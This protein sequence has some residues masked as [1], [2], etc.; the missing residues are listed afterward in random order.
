[1]HTLAILFAAATVGFF[2]LLVRPQL[3]LRTGNSVPSRRKL[4]IPFFACW[5]LAA[6]MSHA[7]RKSNDSNDFQS[8]NGGENSSVIRASYA[9]PERK[10]LAAIFAGIKKLADLSDNGELQEQQRPGCNASVVQLV[11]ATVPL[12]DNIHAHL[13]ALR[14]SKT[15]DAEND[16]SMSPV[17]QEASQ[18]LGA[19][20][21][22]TERVCGM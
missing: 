20:L 16:L 14:N 11:H 12:S 8:S 4:L 2:V 17:Y 7:A 15:P 5:I 19:R 3:A 18:M 1:M 22:N 9:S 21:R 6:V 13:N 10:E